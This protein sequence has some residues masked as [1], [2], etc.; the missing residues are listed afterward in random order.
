[1]AT[2]L[3]LPVAAPAAPAA[4]RI[5]GSIPKLPRVYSEMTDDEVSEY[6]DEYHAG[7]RED[8]SA[9][10]AFCND[11][12]FGER[13]CGWASDEEITKT[14]ANQCPFC[15]TY[16]Y[17]EP[18][19]P[20]ELTSHFSYYQV[21][22]RIVSLACQGPVVV[23]AVLKLIEQGSNR[24]PGA[25][26]FPEDCAE[27]RLGEPGQ[28]VTRC[29]LLVPEGNEQDEIER[30]TSSKEVNC[31]ACHPCSEGERCPCNQV[32]VVHI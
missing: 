31:K 9:A 1:M 28:S 24:P 7:L 27:A 19:P 14:L 2:R 3:R 11:E 16:W 17:G 18:R 25:S 15:G 29:E 8:A 20:T 10:R 12:T 26:D 21:A 4:T 22:G 5:R 32:I 13:P 30:V 23:R 6:L